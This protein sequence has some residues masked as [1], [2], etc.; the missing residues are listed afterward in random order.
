MNKHSKYQWFE[1][2]RR[3]SDTT[4]MVRYRQFIG[5]ALCHHVSSGNIILD[6]ME[7]PHYIT[8]MEFIYSLDKRNV[9]KEQVPIP[10]QTLRLD[11]I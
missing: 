5:K 10:Q 8:F 1:T 9:S 11:N 4:L 2:S 3:S 7:L 6:A